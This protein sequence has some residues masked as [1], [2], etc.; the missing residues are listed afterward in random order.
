MLRQSSLGNAHEMP[1]SAEVR[2]PVSEPWYVDSRRGS[3][4]QSPLTSVARINQHEELMK[5]TSLVTKRL[6]NQVN[7]LESVTVCL[8]DD[9][10][11]DSV[12]DVADVSLDCEAAYSQLNAAISEMESTVHQIQI[13]NRKSTAENTVAEC[14]DCVSR[15]CEVDSLRSRVSV[16]EREA[17]SYRTRL[18]ELST[19]SGKGTPPPSHH[20]E[21]VGPSPLVSAS[22]RLKSVTAALNKALHS[23]KS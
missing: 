10:L 4:P 3:R 8:L 15:Q 14:F 7:R 6:L 19:L 17:V 23:R 18:D 21:K 12:S 22:M 5:S 20:S 11:C 9:K 1:F 2:S 16:L 13:A